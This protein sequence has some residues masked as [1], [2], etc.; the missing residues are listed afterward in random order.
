MQCRHRA[1]GREAD[2][3]LVA[4]GIFPGPDTELHCVLVTW[5]LL[6]SRPLKRLLSSGDCGFSV[7]THCHGP[8]QG[9]AFPFLSASRPQLPSKEGQGYLGLN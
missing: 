6:S 1:E 2:R 3:A 9:T 4:Y 5:L 8:K 7:P